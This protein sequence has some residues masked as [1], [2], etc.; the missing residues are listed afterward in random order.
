MKEII[1]TTLN[2]MKIEVFSIDETL[3]FENDLGMDSQEIME[4]RV[5]VG[6]KIQRD[7]P[8]GWISRNST[9]GDFIQKIN[10]KKEA[11]Y[12]KSK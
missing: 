2:E 12:A 8:E 7:I 10:V 6:K 1:I 5:L 11:C 4:F 3:Q 9:I